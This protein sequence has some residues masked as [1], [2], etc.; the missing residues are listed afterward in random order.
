MFG[1]DRFLLRR[2]ALAAAMAA[3]AGAPAAAAADPGQPHGDLYVSHTAM[4][5]SADTSCATAAYSSVQDAVDAAQPGGTVYVCG[6]IP[7]QESVLVQKD[8]T[9]TGDRGATIQAPMTDAMPNT[10]FFL[11]QGLQTPNSIL[12]VLGDVNVRVE[13]LTLEGPFYNSG[14]APDDFGVLQIGGGRLQLISDQVL[15]VQAADQSG[16]GGCQ[17]G[18]AIQIG[19]RYWPN[20]SGGFNVVDFVGDAQIAGTTVAGYQKNGITVDGPGSEAAISGS[21]LDGGGQTTEIAR[22]GIQI[23]R[24][25]SAEINGNSVNDNEYSGTA[26]NAA[27]TGILV[28]GGCGDPLSVGVQIHNNSLHNN[29]AAI[30]L[31]EYDP[32]CSTAPSSRTGNEVH[33]NTIS[34]TDGETDH[35][36]FTDQFGSSYT[37]YQVGIADTGNGDQIHNNEIT[38]TV[39]GGTDTAYGPQTTPGGPFLAPIDIQT[40]P[41][42]GSHVHNNTYDGQATS[43][44]Y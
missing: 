33:Q 44:P 43:P 39:V 11:D 41:P 32:T 5:G 18:V 20:S 8:L 35:S 13:G 24:G 34:K 42:I 6:T 2:V 25:A 23:S 40:Y 36:P 38:G 3:L 29:D 31:A 22:N 30:E 27:A 1:R 37:G 28:Y 7:Y 4:A 21:T 19:R 16:L 14:C 9:L 10:T 15:D 12:T 17:T 26:A